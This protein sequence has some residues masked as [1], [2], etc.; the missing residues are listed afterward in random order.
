MKKIILSAFFYFSVTLV[1][2]QEIKIQVTNA[3]TG[4]PVN[5]AT[6]S[7]NNKSYTA[8]DS[9]GIAMISISA[10]SEVEISAV[11]FQAFVLKTKDYPSSSL[12]TVKLT[13]AESE[14][15]DV[16]IVASTRSNQNIENAPIKI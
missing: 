2:A 8:T 1:F 13:P 6:I 5:G 14:M 7:K 15:E 16:I 4:L 3:A 9:M 11:G 10:N 12:Y